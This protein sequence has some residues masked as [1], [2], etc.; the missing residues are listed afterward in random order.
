MT[1]SQ[2]DRSGINLQA[3]RRLPSAQLSVVVLAEIFLCEALIRLLS[4]RV[5]GSVFYVGAHWLYGFV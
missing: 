2:H 5:S 3:A 4:V 1:N